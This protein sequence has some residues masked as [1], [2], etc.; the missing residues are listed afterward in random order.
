LGVDV[1]RLHVLQVEHDPALGGAVPGHA[2]A[3]AAD[4]EFQPG[5]AAMA[6]TCATSPASTGGR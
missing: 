3:A 1:Q 6:T 2:V 4:G 5:L